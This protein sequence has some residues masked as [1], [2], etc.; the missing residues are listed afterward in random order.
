[1]KTLYLLR[2]AQAAPVSSPTMGD[3]ER[4]LSAEGTADAQTIGQFMRQQGYCPDF[5]LSSSSVRTIQTSRFIFSALFQTE[6]VKVASRFSRDLYLAPAAKLLAEINAIDNAVQQL[7]TVAHN[8][9]VME[10][11][12]LL[13]KDEERLG[14]YAPGTLTVFRM[15]GDHWADF[16]PETAVMDQVFVPGAA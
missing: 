14:H 4:V 2:H 15:P 16:A 8:P 1:M 12:L 7:M 3:H 11:A 5:V 6:G 13:G 9:G 10:L